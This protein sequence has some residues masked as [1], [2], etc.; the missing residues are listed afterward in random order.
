MIV[1][2]T[3]RKAGID[4]CRRATA[5]RNALEVAESLGAGQLLIG[6]V[7]GDSSHITLHAVPTAHRRR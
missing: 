4:L 7:S 2:E 3:S 6:D 1:V 5:N